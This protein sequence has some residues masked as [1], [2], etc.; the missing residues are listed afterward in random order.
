MKISIGTPALDRP[1]WSYLESLLFLDVPGGN[2]TFRRAGPLAVAH[3][4]NEIAAGFL[5]S[6]DDWLL[7]VDADAVL[8]RGTL[9]RLLSW[10]QPIVSALAFMRYGPCFPAAFKDQLPDGTFAIQHREVAAW[11]DAHPALLTETGA[12]LLEPCPPDALA[13]VDRVGGHCLLLRRDVLASITPPWFIGD[14]PR[15]HGEDFY[16][17]AKAQAA[18]WQ[19][20]LDRSVVAGHLYGER[21]LG[22]LDFMTWRKASEE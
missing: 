17:C 20:M 7:F 19:I 1:T 18:G 21:P 13:P 6:G 10:E 11:T 3:A 9:R 15:G 5:A 22:A 4:R 16:F 12:A 14:G 2:W 8:H